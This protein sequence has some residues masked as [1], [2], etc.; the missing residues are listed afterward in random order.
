M[1]RAS[2]T[3]KR[4]TGPMSPSRPAA[5]RSARLPPAFVGS[6]GCS[7]TPRTS[8]SSGSASS[9]TTSRRASTSSYAS[10]TPK[11]RPHRRGA[12]PPTASPSWPGAS[13]SASSEPAS[14]PCSSSCSCPCSSCSDLLVGASRASA[15]SGL[16]RTHRRTSILVDLD[17]VAAGICAAGEAFQTSRT[18]RDDRVGVGTGLDHVALGDLLLEE[19]VEALPAHAQRIDLTH[20]REYRKSCASGECGSA[21]VARGGGLKVAKLLRGGTPLRFEAA[22]VPAGEPGAGLVSGLHECEQRSARVRCCA[23]R[24]VGEECKRS[25]AE[26]NPVPEG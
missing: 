5:K 24:V 20:E 16:C 19:R 26:W 9:A 13:P 17:H 21:E 18:L 4:S 2:S 12:T 8:R 1:C 10:S 15:A 11:Q 6:A 23:N 3:R 7:R 25:A 14:S 22:R